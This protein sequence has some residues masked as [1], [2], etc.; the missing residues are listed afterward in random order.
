M[1]TERGVCTYSDS[2]INKAVGS[3]ETKS[4][5]STYRASESTRGSEERLSDVVTGGDFDGHCQGK[6]VDTQESISD[7]AS[8]DSHQPQSQANDEKKKFI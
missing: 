2:S 3:G 7:V 5:S 4:G 8:M 6:Q 1:N